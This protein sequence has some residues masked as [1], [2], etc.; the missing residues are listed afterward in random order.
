[1]SSPMLHWA[2]LPGPAEDSPADSLRPHHLHP[3]KLQ[4]REQRAA[5]R[6]RH[7]LAKRVRNDSFA[8]L[9]PHSLA[10]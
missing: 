9:L 8:R 6:L 4:V 5:S 7:S 2:R 3:L 1:M 10:S